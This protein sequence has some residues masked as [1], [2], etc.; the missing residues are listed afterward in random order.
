MH[1]LINMQKSW[2]QLIKQSTNKHTIQISALGSGSDHFKFLSSLALFGWRLIELFKYI[3]E[4]NKKEGHECR[5]STVRV[6]TYSR[7]H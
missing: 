3:L 1:L 6:F 7:K 4:P 5:L 2:C